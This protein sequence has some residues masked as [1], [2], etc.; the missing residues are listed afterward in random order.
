MPKLDR[1][2]ISLHYEVTGNGPPLLML[3]GFMSDHASWT[4]LVPLL[5]DH[6]T[7]VQIDNRTTGQTAPWDAPVS[8]GHMCK[9]AVALMD[10]LEHER[11]HVVGHS[12]GGIIALHMAQ[13]IPARLASTHIAASA[14]IRLPRNTA[15]FANLI[16]IRRSNA[17]PD[18]WLRALFPWL[19]NPRVYHDPGAVDRA[20]ADSLAYP[21]AQSADAMEHQ[22]TALRGFDGTDLA[23]PTC[24]TQVLLGALDLIV[25]PDHVLAVLSHL[26][27]HIIEG[28]GHSIHWD[29]PE[30]V[31]DH[32]RAYAAKHP[33]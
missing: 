14:P 11:F 29:A 12:M 20:V 13:E 31:A 24:P 3:A 26:P 16:A 2:D 4:P 19:F 8:I 18:T 32:V 25:P 28:A 33:I 22:L 30:I 23:S 6:F 7:C 21:H 9:D 27:H 10:A 17:T 5:R 15:L 1:G